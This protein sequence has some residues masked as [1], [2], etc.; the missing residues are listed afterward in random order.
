MCAAS[1]RDPGRT[2]AHQLGPEH[3]HRTG[4]E[5]QRDFARP[6]PGPFPARLPL[7][8][9][10][11]SAALAPPSREGASTLTARRRPGPALARLR[12]QPRA[13]AVAPSMASTASTAGG[14]GARSERPRGWTRPEPGQPIGGVCGVLA[15]RQAGTEPRT[16][17]SRRGRGCGGRAPV[18]RDCPA[19]RSPWVHRPPPPSA[20]GR[21]SGRGRPAPL[22]CALAGARVDYG[23][24]RTPTRPARPA[25]IVLRGR[26]WV[27]DG[28][29]KPSL[30]RALRRVPRAWRCAAAPRG[31]GKN[32]RAACGE[33]PRPNLGRTQPAAHCRVLN[34]DRRS[35]R[36]SEG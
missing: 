22:R 23:E 25:T 24:R 21:A 12:A 29:R 26:T 34:M 15:G 14:E 3:R 28:A 35:R 8:L 19:S 27:R 10:P 32:A 2:L 18:L 1:S 7:A 13:G 17:A 6:E 9:R 30:P 33:V 16:P 11:G 5:R 4:K 31:R 20:R 36:I